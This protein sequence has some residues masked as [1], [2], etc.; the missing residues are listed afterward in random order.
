MPALLASEDGKIPKNELTAFTAGS[1]MACLIRNTVHSFILVGNSLI[2]LS[3][4][5]QTQWQQYSAVTYTILTKLKREVV[6]FNNN[7][8]NNINKI[9][10][11]DDPI[12]TKL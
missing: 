5:T 1:N 8:S 3:P 6:G 10:S 9:S 4:P 2:T 12:L 11:I 7:N